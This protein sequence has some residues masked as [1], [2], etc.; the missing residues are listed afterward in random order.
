MAEGNFYPIARSNTV[1]TPRGCMSEDTTCE[2]YDPT[3]G[4]KSVERQS[5]AEQKKT[6]DLANKLNDDAERNRAGSE[7]RHGYF[8]K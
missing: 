1:G 4:T 6:E 7:M 5:E 3:T 8:L 2:F